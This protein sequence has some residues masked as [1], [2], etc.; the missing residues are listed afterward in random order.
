MGAYTG[1]FREAM[2]EGQ[3]SAEEFNQAL[4]QLGFDDVAVAAA[5]DVSRIENAAGNLQATI[6]G[7]FKD[8]IDLAKPQL[9]DFMSWMSDTL[10]AGFAWIKDVGVPS[11][12]G[13]WDVLANGNFSGPIFGLEAWPPGKCSSPAGT[14]QRISRPRSRRSPRACGTWSA[15][16]AGM[17]HR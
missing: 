7:G 8:M 4:L 12:Q 16:S 5:S 2:S 6:V 13:I 15:R 11:I 1:N 3:I 14:R 9:T 17:A 10:G